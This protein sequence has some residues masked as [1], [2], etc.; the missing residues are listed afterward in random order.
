MLG[1]S[2]DPP[3][4]PKP[5]RPAPAKPAPEAPK[6]AP[7]A[8]KPPETAA[9]AAFEDE[10][11]AIES[12]RVEACAREEYGPAI[13]ALEE[14]RARRADIPW[15]QAI[16]AKILM[17]RAE[18]ART[19]GPLKEKAAEAR[20]RGAADEVRAAAD[21]VARWGLKEASAELDK[22]L[23]EAAGPEKPAPPP[24][25]D[26]P[27]APAAEAS[28]YAGRWEAAMALAADRDYA[29]AIRALEEASQKL[30]DKKIQ[31]EAAGDMEILRVVRGL[32]EETHRVFSK[33]A[34]GQKLTV[35]VF[36]E[37]GKPK[38]VEGTVLR[39]GPGWVELK[40]E[41]ETSIVDFGDLT[42]SSVAELFLSRP[43]KKEGDARLAALFLLLEGEP[44][45]AREMKA[46]GVPEP[47]WNHAKRR[48]AIRPG[49]GPA[50]AEAR[51]LFHEILDPQRDWPEGQRRGG[52]AARCRA[53]LEKHGNTFFVRRHGDALARLMEPAKE[54]LF[55]ASDLKESGTF[56]IV[57]LPKIG[58]VW[59]VSQTV[60]GAAAKDNFVELEF[61]AGPD[62]AWRGWAYAGAC[63]AEAAG[64]CLQATDLKGPAKG[65]AL[66]EMEPGANASQ[67][68]R[69]PATGL[70]PAHAAHP[71][72]AEA[73][74]WGWVPLPLPKYAA[75]GTKKVRVLADTQGA[76]VA[77]VV[78]SSTRAAPPP[79]S[80]MHEIEKAPPAEAAGAERKPKPAEAGGGLV[81]RWS[82]DE[83]SGN[84]AADAGG[85]GF[86]GGLRNGAAW[87]PGRV[88]TALV[89]D[90][91]DDFFEVPES[92][93]L[94]P[95]QI[96]LAAW[97]CP[98]E[99]RS[100]GNTR[101]WIVSKGRNEWAEGHYALALDTRERQPVAY[102]NIGA[103]KEDVFE[104][105]GPAGSVAA[106]NWHHLALTYDGAAFKLY[107]NGA[108]AG[109]KAVNKPRKPGTGPLIMGK[110]GDDWS[111]YK[112][113]ID[114]V[115]LYS[116]ALTA[117]EIQALIRASLAPRPK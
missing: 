42:G 99:L 114:E 80:R 55:S 101:E 45:V 30:E 61:E 83:G 12:K 7:P 87:G 50:E 43:G 32:L 51:A 19:L 8:E 108:L 70:P 77:W 2:S 59:A 38:P 20:K 3:P 65:G 60:A 24:A 85:R 93:E 56:R 103:G 23:E 111:K 47:F 4:A 18:A 48:A 69:F 26:A 116:R 97:F 37:D 107:F 25:A 46:E 62:A 53:L 81:A 74:K 89:F 75:R 1:G 41:K 106:G 105:R 40:G 86:A 14:A 82:F 15:V 88:G 112:G 117:A 6:E 9:P 113:R 13:A 39:A 84:S 49:A 102:L 76:A 96:T 64:F 94:E 57:A 29:G 11:N 95:A 54:Y 34:K 115:W 109:A 10:L 68:L 17:V 98:E 22:A 79:E 100:S 92:P 28:L 110:R 35:R 33:S 31:G 90:G 78:V 63:C 21:R 67:T 91:A 36:G 44:E 58:N 71:A 5:A 52:T 27:P 104:L 66:V 16:E 72:S 73:V